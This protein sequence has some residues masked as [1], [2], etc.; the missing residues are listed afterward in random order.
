MTGF[1]LVIAGIVGPF[2][3]GPLLVWAAK[4]CPHADD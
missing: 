3:G 2:I 1:L 4:G